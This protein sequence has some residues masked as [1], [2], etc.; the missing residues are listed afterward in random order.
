M[1]MYSCVPGQGAGQILVEPVGQDGLGLLGGAR[2]ALHQVVER[3]LGVEHQRVQV[4]G[5]VAGHLRPACWGA[6]ARPARR[7][8]AGPGRP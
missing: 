5:P 1:A 4:A 7:P 3:A 6:T 8:A 2:V